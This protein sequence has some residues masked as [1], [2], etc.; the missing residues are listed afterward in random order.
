MPSAE[1]VVCVDFGSTFTKAVLVDLEA[2]SVVASAS[3]PT[4]IETDVLEGYDGFRNIEQALQASAATGPTLT[5]PTPS[6]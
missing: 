5:S 2:G 4:T 1:T 3:Q 6:P